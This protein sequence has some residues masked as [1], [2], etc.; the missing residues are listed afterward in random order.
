MYNK[1]YFVLKK[2][3]FFV[4]CFT[5]FNYL[6]I[7]DKLIIYAH[8]NKLKFL[9]SFNFFTTLSKLLYC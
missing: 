6:I 7:V 5:N 3:I 4:I 2:F 8:Y 1:K 9:S